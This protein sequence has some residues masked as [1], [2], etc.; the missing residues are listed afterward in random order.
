MQYA[1]CTIAQSHSPES[2]QR[3]IVFLVV[4]TLTQI[5]QCAVAPV[6]LKSALY[7]RS[8]GG[9]GGGGAAAVVVAGTGA[10][11]VVI[12]GQSSVSQSGAPY[13]P[14]GAAAS[15]AALHCTPPRLLCPMMT[16]QYS[17]V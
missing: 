2:L 6:T 17:S 11:A 5:M 4:E 8:S 9:G 1:T 10:A 14:A 16:S 3:C 7:G 13:R 12:S 15:R